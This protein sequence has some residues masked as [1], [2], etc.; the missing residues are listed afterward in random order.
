MKPGT[1]KL[2]FDW[3]EPPAGVD[4]KTTGDALSIVMSDDI[5]YRNDYYGLL[6]VV[7]EKNTKGDSAK[8]NIESFSDETEYEKNKSKYEEVLLLFKG[9]F[10]KDD[11][12]DKGEDGENVKYV[13]KS[14]DGHKDKIV[15]N[16][17]I[18]ALVNS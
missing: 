5:K 8:Y 18:D 4:K 9:D 12:Y 2:V 11:T 16:G 15:I 6:A 14:L 1:Y 7:Q 3:I 13:A 10:I 17:C